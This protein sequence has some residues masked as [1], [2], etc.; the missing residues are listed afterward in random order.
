MTSYSRLQT[1]VLT[2]FVDA[3]CIFRDTGAAAGK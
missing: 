2:K 3:L 1:N